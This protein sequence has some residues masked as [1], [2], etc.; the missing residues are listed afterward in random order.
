MPR[1]VADGEGHC[2]FAQGDAVRVVTATGFAAGATAEAGFA[3]AG[4]ALHDWHDA[5]DG[6]PRRAANHSRSGPAERSD[7]S[8]A[9]VTQANRKGRMS[10]TPRINGNKLRSN[11]S[12]PSRDPLPYRDSAGGGWR[13]AS[14]RGMCA[15][16]CYFPV[17]LRQLRHHPLKLWRVV[18]D[19][20][21]EKSDRVHH[22]SGFG[23][24]NS[25]ASLMNRETSAL[26]NDPSPG[27]IFPT[28]PSTG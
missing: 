11:T 18:N 23:S 10:G 5:H 9:R 2:P 20:T 6:A 15:K 7:V 19:E 14:L 26:R 22:A 24:M 27:K 13:H 3:T 12:R 28:G 21:T 4:A 25:G 8:S 1:R 16:R 17:T